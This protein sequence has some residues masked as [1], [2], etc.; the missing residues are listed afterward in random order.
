MQ[1]LAQQDSALVKMRKEVDLE[2]SNN[3][4]D[5]NIR[6]R[7]ELLG[8]AI[9]A[10]EGLIQLQEGKMMNRHQNIINTDVLEDY[11]G[12]LESDIIEEK[13]KLTANLRRA[14]AVAKR[15]YEDATSGDAKEKPKQNRGL[16]F[17]A[18]LGKIS[19]L[20]LALTPMP[21]Y[22]GVWGKQP[23]EQVK[24]VESVSFGYLLLA[25]LSYAVWTSYA[26]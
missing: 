14:G 16:D 26:F 7:D 13:D 21:T 18:T 4:S 2:L 11:Y 12:S 24:R 5:E 23:A 19:S 8:S 15:L 10:I 1:L 25:T 6:E 22:L 9:Q 20:S 3:E 17:L